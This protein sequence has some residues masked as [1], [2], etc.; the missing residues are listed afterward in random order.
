MMFCHLYH[1][2]KENF[3]VIKSLCP[4]RLPVV[5]VLVKSSTFP[6]SGHRLRNR[7]DSYGVGFGRLL[8]RFLE[9]YVS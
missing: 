1:F 4:F 5:G 8:L 2:L 9:I 3:P 6:L 7:L